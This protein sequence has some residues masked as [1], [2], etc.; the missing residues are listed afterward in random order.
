MSIKSLFIKTKQA[1]GLLQ[2]CS[3]TVLAGKIS[4]NRLLSACTL[5]PLL[6]LTVLTM[7]SHLIKYGVIIKREY[8][9]TN[10]LSTYMFVF[11][12]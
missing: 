9:Y 4:T 12:H 2:C 6:C 7:N 8:K 10:F 5:K 11:A 3:G 1:I